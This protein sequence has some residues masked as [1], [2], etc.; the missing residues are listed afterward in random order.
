MN[1]DE[2]IILNMN[3]SCD[4]GMK[5]EK[6]KNKKWEKRSNNPLFFPR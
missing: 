5:K 1:Q 3:F 6:K 2:K 4:Q